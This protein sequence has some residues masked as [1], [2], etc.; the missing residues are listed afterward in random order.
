MGLK[1]PQ[2]ER[3]YS[4]RAF[5]KNM[6]YKSGTRKKKNVSQKA[7]DKVMEMLQDGDMD[8]R[9]D[10]MTF[11][12][13]FSEKKISLQHYA[14][15]VKFVGYRLLG[16]KN[17]EAFR[18]VFP[19]R[20]EALEEVSFENL[21]FVATRYGNNKTVTELM[22]MA[23]VPTWIANMDYYQEA[24]NVNVMLMRNAKSEMVKHQA[25]KTLMEELRPPE[26]VKEIQEDTITITKEDTL[27]ALENAI[28]N[29]A[30]KQVQGIEDGIISTADAIDV[31]L[32][33]TKNE[34][35]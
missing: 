31:Q 34:E 1:M 32:V 33:G 27:Q 10:F 3:S 16:Y 28:F 35:D 5:V 18:R 24:I 6:P 8:F 15:A 12:K 29:L 20:A 21:S 4:K 19:E 26:P 7:Y 17:V 2:K 14:E 9:N 22:S 23:M 11:S 13:V 30:E 25:A